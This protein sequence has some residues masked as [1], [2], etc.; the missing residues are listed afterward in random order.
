MKHRD[1][2][3]LVQS[4]TCG[5][6]VKCFND[7][8]ISEFLFFAPLLWG[9][10]LQGSMFWPRAHGQIVWEPREESIRCGLVE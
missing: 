3:E 2:P 6:V 10:N 4:H 9:K 1:I 8:P 5:V 7:R